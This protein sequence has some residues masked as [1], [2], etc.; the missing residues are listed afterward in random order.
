MVRRL[1]Y[2]SFKTK[3]NK[4]HIYPYPK[5]KKGALKHTKH[6]GKK[7]IIKSKDEVQKLLNEKRAI[8]KSIRRR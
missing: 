1:W 7:F 8:I 6:E 5:T 3:D 2:I 4:Y